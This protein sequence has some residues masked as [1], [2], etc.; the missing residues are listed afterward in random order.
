MIGDSNDPPA[1]AT[2]TT[3]DGWL[4]TGGLGYMIDCRLVVTGGGKDLVV[5]SGLNIWPQDVE[6][7][8]EALEDV[9]GSDVACFS[10]IE[11]DDNER[12]IVVLQCRLHDAAARQNLRKRVAATVRR[13]CGAG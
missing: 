10:V 4:G 13:P 11:P 2:D 3:P 12:M 9:R 1:T 5:L 8:V 7:A 6:W